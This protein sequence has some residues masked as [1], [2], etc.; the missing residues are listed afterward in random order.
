MDSETTCGFGALVGG[1]ALPYFPPYFGKSGQLK[2]TARVPRNANPKKSG[3]CFTWHAGF[4]GV[5]LKHI[6]GK[7]SLPPRSGLA[8]V[9]ETWRNPA[10][11]EGGRFRV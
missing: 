9:G 2:R 11:P 8:Q 6:H 10:I 7:T 5:T 4:E 3:V 1:E